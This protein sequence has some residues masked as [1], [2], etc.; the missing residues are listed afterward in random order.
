MRFY[1]GPPRHE[2]R[3]SSKGRP[4][5]SVLEKDHEGQI[6]PHDPGTQGPSGV[7]GA[8]WAHLMTAGDR[9]SGL[10][11]REEAGRAWW[12]REKEGSG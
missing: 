7:G 10:R 1:P 6:H 9:E 5:S 4:E 8:S 3:V 11:S 2:V 12:P